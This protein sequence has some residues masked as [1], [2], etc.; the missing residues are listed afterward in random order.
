VFEPKEWAALTGRSIL[1]KL[2]YTLDAEFAV[3]PVAQDLQPWQWVRFE[4]KTHFLLA[5]VPEYLVL[6]PSPS[7]PS[8][9]LPPC[10]LQ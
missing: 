6:G 7:R 4:V 5:S 2:A 3:N 10:L 9:Y 8:M 1:P